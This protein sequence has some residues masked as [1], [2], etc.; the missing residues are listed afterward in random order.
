MDKRQP[1]GT[2]TLAHHVTVTT[3]T[4][5]QPGPDSGLVATIQ[6]LYTEVY[7]EPPYHEGPTEVQEF[8]DRWNY[9][10]HQPGF[11]IV[12]AHRT[13]NLVGF[14]FGFPLGA[15]SRWWDG[16]LDPVD[17]SVTAEDGHRSFAIME[18]A[19]HAEHRR[20][21]LGRVLHDTLLVGC[22][23][24][25]A[26]LLTRPEAAPALAAYASWGYETVGR[27]RPGPNAPIY[28]AMT[29]TLA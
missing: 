22:A 28:V 3:V 17:A 9:H 8:I 2:I 4:L 12:L 11:R 10:V 21:G 24:P 29:R 6:P 14:C 23:R 18:L 27:L 1:V 5:T 26:T 20:N 19:V 15:Q 16:L 13:G 25:R 7:A